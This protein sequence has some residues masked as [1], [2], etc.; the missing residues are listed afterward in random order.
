RRRFI[1]RG[2]AA[3]I[4]GRIVRP[5][6]IVLDSIT[7]SSLT[8]AGGRSQ[9]RAGVARFG[10]LVSF[11]A[12]MT[13][14]EG[15]F[16]DVQRQIEFTYGKIPEDYLTSTT[17]VFAD[18]TGLSV[19]D[20]PKFTIKHLRAALNSK[21]PTGSGEPGIALGGDTVVEGASV[22]GHAL[23]VELAVPVF[24]QYDTRAKLLTASDDPEFV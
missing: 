22:D 7:A 16:D 5:A 17:N 15:L 23:V 8:V 2:N 4:G 6:D 21:S 24:Q 12:A 20:K 14:A 19:G 3:A 13:S 10:E 1:F 18:V 9:A 11:S